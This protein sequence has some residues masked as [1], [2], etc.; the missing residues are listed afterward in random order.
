MVAGRPADRDHPYGHGKVE[1][2]SAGVEGALIAVAAILI[3]W[4]AV[5]DLLRG[6]ELAR[7]D[8]GLAVS[9]VLAG[10][11]ALLGGYLVRTGRRHASDAL[12]A[13]GNHVLADVATTVGV[14]AGSSRCGSPES[15]RSIR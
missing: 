9:A 4:Q 6:P 5:A 14:I 8:L 7:L 11:N 10:G 2:F 15:P 3:V 13:D 1:F 12:V